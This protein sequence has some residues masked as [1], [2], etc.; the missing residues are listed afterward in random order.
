SIVS[1]LRA[2]ISDLV[3]SLDRAG[4]AAPPSHSAIHPIFLGDAKSA[5]AASARLRE[6]GFLVPAIRPPTVPEG[7]SRLRVSL[8]AA[9]RRDEIE[10][11]AIALAQCLAA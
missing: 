7:T 3:S 10:A 11:L 9:H 5:V 8:S 4:V 1:A 6:R 2:R